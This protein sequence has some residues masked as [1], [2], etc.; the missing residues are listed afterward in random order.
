VPGNLYQ[1]G[2]VWWARYQVS[3]KEYRKSLRTTVKRE[4]QQ[5]LTAELAEVDHFRFYGE[6]RHTW[7]EAVVEWSK[8][9][10][11]KP[12][13]LTRY[14]VSFNQLRDALDPLYI[15]QID[16]RTMSHIARRA[17]VTNAT[18]RRDLTAVSA[19][20]R[21]CVAHG[22]AN[23][24]AAK[25]FDRSV[26]REQRDPIVLPTDADIDAVVALAPGGLGPMIR[27]AQYSGMRQ[28]EL[29]GLMWMQVDRQRG[30]VTLTRT[31][32]NRVRAVPLDDRALGTLPGT[33]PGP[34]FSHDGKRYANVAS[35]FAA[36]TRAAGKAALKEGKPFRR[37]RFHDL[38]HWFAVNYLRRG[39]NIYRLQGV[40]GH[41]SIK[42]TEIY[43][44]YLTP[45]EQERAK[46]AQT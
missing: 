2:K 18:R 27:M 46:V 45:E 14:L 39:G 42:T 41:S 16:R 38:R 11:I 29:A 35:R 37:F 44:A 15:D 20:L 33:E 5:R 8:D 1:R 25:I 32:T 40:L 31:K 19:V 30:V 26:I 3:G 34:V 24:N 9:P 28:E 17:G 21:W 22:W 4:A 6:N 23:D 13:V 36:L 12:G 10:G 43:L 7:K